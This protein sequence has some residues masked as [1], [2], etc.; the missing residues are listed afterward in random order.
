[1]KGVKEITKAPPPKEYSLLPMT[2]L[3]ETVAIGQS[4]RIAKLM[5]NYAM[6]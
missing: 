2:W 4:G 6:S 5:T 3:V 1:M